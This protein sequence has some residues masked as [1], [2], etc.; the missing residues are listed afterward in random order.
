[1][2]H[3]SNR[4]SSQASQAMGDQDLIVAL[5]KRDWFFFFKENS[6]QLHVC[7]KMAGP[8]A[9]YSPIIISGSPSGPKGVLS[10]LD[11]R[12]LLLAPAGSP[13]PAAGSPAIVEFPKKVEK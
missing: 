5:E 13:P 4:P 8:V 10:S 11:G 3:D 9:T 1:M 6:N 2:E 12:L 7:H